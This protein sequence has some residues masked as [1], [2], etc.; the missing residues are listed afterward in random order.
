MSQRLMST[1]YP[2]SA[3]GTSATLT[4]YFYRRQTEGVGLFTAGVPASLALVFPEGR[5]DITTA[6]AVVD[7]IVQHLLNDP[8]FTAW[9]SPLNTTPEAA[10][11]TALDG[12]RPTSFGT[13]SVSI[14]FDGQFGPVLVS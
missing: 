8:T 2:T 4:T 6:Q 10:L 13:T 14:W 11:R 3:A 7:A 1:G 12:W 5:T 9:W